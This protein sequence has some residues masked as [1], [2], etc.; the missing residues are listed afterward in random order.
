MKEKGNFLKI[1]HLFHYSESGF[2]FLELMLM[3]IILVSLVGLA[4]LGIV[5]FIGSAT[6]EAKAAEEYQ[7]QSSVSIYLA[8]G[9]TIS[10]PFVVTPSDQGV[11]DPYLKGNLKN[12]WIVNVDGNVKQVDDI[13]ESGKLG[14]MKLDGAQP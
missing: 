4:T 10:E 8:N 9:Y 1:L 14:T 12:S 2:T 5:R 3:L 11:L 6:E 7:V 13:E